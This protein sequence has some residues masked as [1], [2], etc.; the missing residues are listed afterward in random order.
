MGSFYTWIDV[1]FNGTDSDKDKFKKLLFLMNKDEWV[2]EMLKDDFELP[3]SLDDAFQNALL[4]CLEDQ[5]EDY[6]RYMP[7]F[8][9]E[10]APKLISALFP[11][12][13][14]SISINWDY[15]AGGG[16]TFFEA[17]YKNKILTVK[18]CQ[19][20][21]DYYKLSDEMQEMYD[22]CGID[23]DELKEA[24]FEANGVKTIEPSR[25]ERYETSFYKAGDLVAKLEEEWE[26]VD[27]VICN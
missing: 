6:C 5:R 23:D 22:E 25:D 14:F 15:S 8:E 26:E 12:S 13:S 27:W 17:E 3:L 24:L 20:E 2:A 7:D 21:D 11:E 19:T 18:K 16:T 10:E 9:L 1:D 4:G